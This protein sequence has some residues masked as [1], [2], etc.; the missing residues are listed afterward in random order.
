MTNT[1]FFTDG[2][3]FSC[4]RCSSCCRFEPGY[5]FLC[6]KDMS[7]LLTEL[8]MDKNAFIKTYCRWIA[9]H[10]GESLSLKEKSNKDCI[11]WND[12]CTVY[13]ARP[14]QCRTFPF[15]ESIVASRKSWQNTAC[16]CPGINSGE[17]H[18]GEEIG[19]YLSLASSQNY[20]NRQGNE[21]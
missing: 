3:R 6:D 5:V 14:L 19:Q 7:Q 8:K 12:G 1:P 9:F 17:T 10:G 18:T 20:I 4:K 2:L 15:W 16:E 13:H 21:P 11:F